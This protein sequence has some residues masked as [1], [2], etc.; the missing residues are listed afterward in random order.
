MTKIRD[1]CES[2]NPIDLEVYP[3]NQRDFD[4]CMLFCREASCVS[5][6][7]VISVAPRRMLTSGIKIPRPDAI[8]FNA[9]YNIEPPYNTYYHRTLAPMSANPPSRGPV[10]SGLLTLKS[11]MTST[12][13]SSDGHSMASWIIISVEL[14]E[15]GSVLLL[16]DRLAS[17]VWYCE[18]RVSLP[19]KVDGDR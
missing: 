17:T 14:S 4:T 3:V 18:S 9:L 1:Q 15:E 10:V 8:A 7:H 2:I 6:R 12:S 19:E 13:S 11:F 5:N 16:L